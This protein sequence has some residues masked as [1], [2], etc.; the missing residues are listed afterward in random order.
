MHN[1]GD[2][3]PKDHAKAAA[4]FT[5]ACDANDAEA[6]GRLSLLTMKG[7]GVPL[8]DARAAALAQKACAGGYASSC[9]GVGYRH[10]F[11]DGLPKDERMAVAMFEKACSEKDGAGCDGLGVLYQTGTGVA[12]DAAKAAALFAKGCQLGYQGSCKRQTAKAASSATPAKATAAARAAVTPASTACKIVKV[13]PGVD[14]VASVER[15]IQARGGSPITGGSG[16]SKYRISAMSGD[17]QDAGT[18]VMAVNYDFDAAGPAGRL[19]AVTVVNHAYTGPGYEK[20][21]ASRK[22][23]AAAIAGP[24]QQKSATELVASSPGCQLRLLPN[25]GTW[26]IYEVYQLPN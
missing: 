23:A 9:T 8:D 1:N 12:E 21:L 3:M 11:G 5:I 18:D 14:T 15:D 20:L 2:G 16:L 7:E 13:Q 26:F 25:A 19:V 24:L 17:Y 22:A 4:L 10:L 6:C